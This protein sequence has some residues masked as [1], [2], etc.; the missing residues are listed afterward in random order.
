[1]INYRRDHLLGQAGVLKVASDLLL[2]SIPVWQPFVDF[3]SDLMLGNGRKVQVKTSRLNT[4]KKGLQIYTFATGTA[5]TRRECDEPKYHVLLG[6]DEKRTWIMPS[7]ILETYKTVGIVSQLG[8]KSMNKFGQWENRWGMLETAKV[9]M[10]RNSLDG[11]AGNLRVAAELLAMGQPISI[12][13]V[14]G[15]TD[16]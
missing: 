13:P 3:G 15:G 2:R 12:P 14:D 6:W 5:R 11:A 9:E 16:I 4:T 8:P 7:E 1:M 10:G